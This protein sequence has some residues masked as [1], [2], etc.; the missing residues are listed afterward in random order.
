[1]ARPTE[2]RESYT[3]GIRIPHSSPST[4]SNSRLVKLFGYR[5]ASL[6]ARNEKE[7]WL[8]T[9]IPACSGLS[10]H[11]EQTHMLG[12]TMVPRLRRRQRPRRPSRP[13]ADVLVL[14]AITSHPQEGTITNRTPGPF[15]QEQTTSIP[16]DLRNNEPRVA[17]RRSLPQQRDNDL[18]L[19]W[20]NSSSDDLRENAAAE[21]PSFTSLTKDENQPLKPKSRS[22]G[23]QVALTVSSVETTACARGSLNYGDHH[24]STDDSSHLPTNTAPANGGRLKAHRQV[25]TPVLTEAVPEHEYRPRG[26]RHVARP[27][28]AADGARRT[29][30]WPAR[31]RH[32]HRPGGGRTVAPLPGSSSSPSPAWLEDA[33]AGLEDALLP[34]IL[35][36]EA[37][38]RPTREAGSH[39]A[40]PSSLARM[41][42]IL[43]AE[44]RA[45]A[46]TRLASPHHQ[47]GDHPYG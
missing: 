46:A 40:R 12:V 25:L 37:G 21:R 33:S 16:E 29:W 41:M 20:L 22:P 42:N 39:S 38:H 4:K 13:T 36:E 30:T 35:E 23:A 8:Y 47:A 5:R 6:N 28:G 26:V 2:P 9:R 17:R 10:S 27:L 34:Q 14:K 45:E 1:M 18:R 11:K 24:L 19:G 43:E 31:A 44:G 3:S 7:A 32:D 15:P